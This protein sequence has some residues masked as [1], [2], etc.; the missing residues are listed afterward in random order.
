MIAFLNGLFRE[1]FG[2][3][4][5]LRNSYYSKILCVATYSMIKK[6]AHVLRKIFV[7]FKKIIPLLYCQTIVYLIETNS[8]FD[9]FCLIQTNIQFKICKLL[10]LTIIY[11]LFVLVWVICLFQRKMYLI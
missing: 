2:A 9:D 6:T 11:F 1:I 4:I 7:W 3:Y 5:P 10:I 8:L